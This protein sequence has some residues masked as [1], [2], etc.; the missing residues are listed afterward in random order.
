MTYR[1]N[2]S[3]AQSAKARGMANT[4]PRA[5]L[6]GGAGAAIR[7]G[8][9]SGIATHVL[10]MGR[11]IPLLGR[12]SQWPGSHPSPHTS[13]N[14]RTG[15]RDN[16]RVMPLLG[17]IVLLL[18]F[19][20]HRDGLDQREVD[21]VIRLGDRRPGRRLARPRWL[22]QITAFLLAMSLARQASAQD[23][24]VV[25]PVALFEPEASE[26]QRLD[27]SFVLRPQLTA[28]VRYDSNIYSIAAP[29]QSDAIFVLQPRLSL[30]S[31]F[32]RH[33]VELYGG[34]DL[35]RHAEIGAEN[36][37]AW[38]LGAR[39]LL[40]MAGWI[41]I[42]PEA[43]IAR[44]VEQRGTAGD[45]FLSDRPITY[46]NK[47]LLLGISRE[48]QRLEVALNGRISRTDYSDTS[49]GGAPID[50]SGRD[51]T[52]RSAE[53]RVG[54]DLGSRVQIFA[55]LGGNRLTYQLPASQVRNSSGHSLLGGARIRVT[56]LFDFEV[57]TG[58]LRQNFS[59]PAFAPLSAINYALAMNW[60]P[61]PGWQIR[62][63]ADRT[64]DPSPIATAPAI[65]RTS[66]RLEAKHVV[67]TSVLLGTSLA[68]VRE[69]YRAMPRTDRRYEADV[70]LTYRLTPKVGVIAGLGYRKQDGGATGRTYD[71]VSAGLAVR[72]VG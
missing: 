45:Q 61:R 52:Y 15:P 21:R 32:P 26:G 68:H 33:R 8:L 60:T 19:A 29:K 51:N 41:N 18:R 22:L 9:R 38:D 55:K 46:T 40:E 53:V 35:Q 28:G 66:Y 5:K 25:T 42:R 65:F 6:R 16:G 2:S 39:A 67:G 44:G 30:Q 3:A 63:A 11:F 4:S 56:S 54:Y 57:A 23:A 58:Y 27:S 48:Q 62:A 72:V 71:G 59:D 31:D 69:S 1:K 70:S 43:R 17:D 7:S 64:V 50:L 13:G 12:V 14:A 47:E 20:L 36:S 24:E 37:E 49:L 34:A 10:T